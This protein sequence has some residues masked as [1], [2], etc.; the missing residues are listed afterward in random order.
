MP[1]PRWTPSR[2]CPDRPD[3]LSGVLLLAID[4]STTA[5]TAALHDGAVVVAESTTLDARGHAEHL[6]PGIVSV[7]DAARATPS[8]VT[9]IA[10]GLGPGPF[11]GLRVG[12]VTARTL[13]LVTGAALHGV[14]SLDALAHEAWRTGAV[15]DGELLVA[16]DAR[17]KEVYWARYAVTSDRV[18]RLTEPDVGHPADL[19]A[20]VTSLVTVGRGPDLYPGTFTRHG[21]PR[22]VSAGW[23]ADLVV[24]RL[25]RG[26]VGG[27]HEPIYL[28][29]PDA[30]PSVPAV[31]GES[32]GSATG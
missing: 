25:A 18:D 3:S 17:R 27:G 1:R 30:V 31:P 15:G 13:A 21:I 20:E 28:R 12:I 16:T 29:R 14:C 32:A 6:A 24:A 10:V 19:P 2:G 8:D 5:I 22:D 26:D 11:T 4:T 9:D 23:L 7:L